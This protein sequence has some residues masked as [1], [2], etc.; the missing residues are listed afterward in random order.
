MRVVRWLIVLLALFLAFQFISL[1]LSWQKQAILGAVLVVTAIVMNRISTSKVVTISLMLLSVVITGRYG[2]WRIGQLIDYFSDEANN[3][4]KIDSVLMLILLSAEIYTI[5]IMVL[6][7]M[8][9]VWPLQRR[10]VPLP[11]DEELWPHVD[12]LI[13]TY[14]E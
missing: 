11:A 6:G 8:Q 2:W 5:L 10:P 14:N 12:L 9:T 3:P 7:Y 1:Y 13:P 4:Y